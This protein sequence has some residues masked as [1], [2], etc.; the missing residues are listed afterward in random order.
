MN[1]PYYSNYF[2]GLEKLWILNKIGGTHLIKSQ[3]MFINGNWS[4][5]GDLCHLI[6]SVGALYIDKKKSII[7]WVDLEDIILFNNHDL[8]KSKENWKSKENSF[9]LKIEEIL[10]K[11]LVSPMEEIRTTMTKRPWMSKASLE[12]IF[13]E[14]IKSTKVF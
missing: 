4:W 13:L 14:Q 1:T 8:Q 10:H 3:D 7:K 9:F 12:A 11:F 5:N 6:K 2:N